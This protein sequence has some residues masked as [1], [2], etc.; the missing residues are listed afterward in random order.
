VLAFSLGILV[1]WILWG[2]RPEEPDRGQVQATDVTYA[3]LSDL[4]EQ[5]NGV[6]QPR[7]VAAPRPAAVGPSSSAALEDFAD[8]PRPMDDLIADLVASPEQHATEP[9]HPVASPPRSPEPVTRPQPLAATEPDGVAEPTPEP[10]PVAETE[11]TPEAAPEPAL[12]VRDDLRRIEGIGPKL[13]AALGA[14]GIATYA[15]LAEADA[16]KLSGILRAQ[17]MRFAPNLD[18]WI[19]QAHLLADGD[20][21]GF[22]ALQEELVAGR[23]ARARR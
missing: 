3:E 13:A 1:G 8:A 11:P 19:A 7:A 12:A 6:P 5:T 4:V 22:A 10:E 18:T 17:G 16:E 14:G 15:Q 9:D 2:L 20:E 21:Q 23:R